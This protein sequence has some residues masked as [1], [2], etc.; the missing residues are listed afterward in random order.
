MTAI[1]PQRH[2]FDI[3]EDV[4]YL[5][6]AYNSPMLRLS[7][8]RLAEGAYRKC[9]PWNRSPAS[10]FD[11]A[12]D[13]R[14]A[15]AGTLGAPA[16]CVAIVPSASYGLSAAA[17]ALEPHV[18]DGREILLVENAFPSNVFPWLRLAEATGG[19]VVTVPT[20]P[21]L[22]WT[23]AVLDRI[24]VRT[25]VVA[26]AQCHWTNGA[27]FDL[28]RISD[29]ARAVGAVLALDATQS[30]GAVPLDFDRIRPDFCVA[31]GYKWLLC[32]YGLSLMYVDPR[33][34]DARP[35]EESWLARTGAEDFAALANYSHTYQAGARRFDVGQKSVPTLL[36]GGIAALRQLGDWGVAAVA[37]SLR[38]INRS[39][40]EAM[41]GFPLAPLPEAVRA[42]HLLGFTA[43]A[44][45]PDDLLA[46]L[47]SEKVYVSR[48]GA[49]L[50]FAPHLHVTPNDLDR[51]RTAMSKVL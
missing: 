19:R 46:R 22:D 45:L 48:R 21:D 34:H 42:P 44:R 32:P 49:S 17:R 37:E 6:C 23:V 47:A 26:L 30:L 20:P 9:H 18:P 13:F 16:D 40:V 11:E 3:P 31:A 1:P 5:N 4:V 10:F 2:L 15:V 28:E 29:A 36:P 8:D 33:W 25:A 27:W 41:S 7:A 12:E 38:G 39:I 24:G 51:L 43:E 35:L 50:R 14:A